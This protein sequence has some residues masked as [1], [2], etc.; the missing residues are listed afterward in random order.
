[1]EKNQQDQNLDSQ[2]EKCKHATISE[3]AR[4]LKHHQLLTKLLGDLSPDQCRIL[5]PYIKR[6]SEGACCDYVYNFIC[7]HS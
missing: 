2:E 6:K 4:E 7:W 1:M 3:L 5:I